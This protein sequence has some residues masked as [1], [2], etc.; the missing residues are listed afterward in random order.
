MCELKFDDSKTAFVVQCM[1]SPFFGG[2]DCCVGLLIA[3]RSLRN[4]DATVL[5]AAEPLIGTHSSPGV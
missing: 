1:F 5:L 2:C 3:R 4:G